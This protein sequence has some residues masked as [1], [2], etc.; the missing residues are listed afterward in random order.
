MSEP[1]PRSDA[2]PGADTAAADRPKVVLFDLDGTLIDSR[3]SIL[4]SHRHAFRE[5]A[6]I[7][8]DAVGY[9]A[10]ALLAMRIP[11]AFEYFGRPELAEQGD[12]AYDEYYRGEGYKETTAYEGADEVLRRISRARIPWGV[13]TNKGRDRTVDA[14]RHLVGDL[15]DEMICLITAEDTVERKP[16]PAPIL[17]G[18]ERAGIGPEGV[19]YVGD[20]PHDVESAIAAGVIPIGAAYGYYGA[21][22]LRA[23]G[24]RLIIER[25]LDLLELVTSPDGERPTEADTGRLG[26]SR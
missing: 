12:R 18:L 3:A 21:E 17:A 7:D 13:V 16:H 10:G 20:G 6:G 26:G 4:A 24:A 1:T 14:L 19:A 8:I 11:E 2:R 15:S 22:P 9:D 5:V 23:A 25:P